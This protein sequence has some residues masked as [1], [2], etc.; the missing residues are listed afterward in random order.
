MFENIHGVPTADAF[1]RMIKKSALRYYGT[2]LRAF[3]EHVTSNRA[4]VERGL[5]ASLSDFLATHV[6][7]AAAGEVYRAA[8][9]FALIGTGGEIATELGLTGWEKGESMVAAAACYLA[10]LESRGTS[11]ASDVESGI[12]QVRAFIEANGSSRFQIF[13]P[14][15]A[16]HSDVSADKIVNRAGFRIDS[17]D[18]E[19]QYLILPEVFRREVCAGFDYRLIARS[20][21]E[22]GHLISEPGTHLTIRKVLP[23][24]GKSRVYSIKSS[25][26]GGEE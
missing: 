10:W 19:T 16:S 22:S 23:E 5:R 2:P 4:A 1:S 17:E 3:L 11:G 9:R 15:P 18:G 7:S 21:A 13:R 20:L 14:R 24:L 12:R 8:S 6:D 25:I 26:C